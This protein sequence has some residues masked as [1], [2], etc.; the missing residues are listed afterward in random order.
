VCGV[1]GVYDRLGRDHDRELDR[2]LDALIHRGPD[3]GGSF[4]EGP[5]ALGNRRLAILDLTRAGAQPMLDPSGRYV[6]TYNGEVFNYRELRAELERAGH[7]FAS[8]GDTEVLLAMLA[9]WGADA[10]PRLNGMFAFALYDRSTRTLFCARDRLGVKPL[11]Y[12]WDGKR[13]AFASEH[14]ALLAGGF[15]A[16]EPCPEAMYEYIVRGYVTGGRSF[17]A[18]IRSLPPGSAVW[19]SPTGEPRF[20][21]W[22]RCP[23]EP[24]R[25][26]EPAELAG[27]VRELIADAVRLRLRSDVPV[28][29]HL[30]GGLDSSTVV[31]AAADQGTQP[32]V[33]FTGA[34]PEDPGCDERAFSR[35]VN[36]KWGL[37][38][39]EVEIGMDE[40][41]AS[42]DRILWHLDEPVAGP[43]AFPQL[44]VC[45]LA[46]EHGVK[47]VLGGQ[48]GDEL[49]G[50]YLRHHALHLRAALRHGA[51]GQRARA[52]AAL[53]RLVAGERRRRWRRARI[54]ARGLRPSFLASVDAG[55]RQEVDQAPRGLREAGDRMRWDLEHY[56]PA[57]LHV[58]DRT[59]MAASLESRTPLL[60][61]RLV[62][63]VGRVPSAHHFASGPKSLLRAAAG[64]WLP[65][66][67][68][69]RT[70]KLGFPTPLHR[71]RQ[72]PALSRLV[73]DLTSPSRTSVFEDGYLAQAPSFSASEL[74]TVMSVQGW[75]RRLDGSPP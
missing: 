35:A 48:G 45:E 17:Y 30:S 15:G 24:D 16:R 28:G 73:S 68:A 20:L 72:H 40:L 6:L 12:A 59:S 37:V 47:V 67:V 10:L 18:G 14:K 23:R 39:R 46:R 1:A 19:L 65:A 2:M 74:W 21:R 70:D 36:A 31:G 54:S 4:G 7:D 5:V 22:W 29:A 25:E 9:R 8:G 56:L 61:Y 66:P 11:V 63:L 33:T 41:A 62:E 27:S 71:W 49:F 69:A 55:F 52:A 64:D 58:E 34:M 44:A 43:G 57:L 60:D 3:D 42:F 38:G 13:F 26:A 75:L 53:A 50:G 51:P 32:L